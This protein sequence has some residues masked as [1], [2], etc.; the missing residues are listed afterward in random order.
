[1]K[2]CHIWG[3]LVEAHKWCTWDGVGSVCVVCIKFVLQ[4]VHQ[5]ESPRL[6]DMSNCFSC[7]H[8]HIDNYLFANS[9]LISLDVSFC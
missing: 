7:D 4:G 2:G 9:C 3:L 1:M 8:H 6:S 5:F